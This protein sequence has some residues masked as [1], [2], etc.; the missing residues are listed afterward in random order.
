MSDGSD[1]DRH[2]D[3]K[4]ILTDDARQSQS[5]HRWGLWPA[6]REDS[7]PTWNEL[8]RYWFVRYNPLYFFSAFCVLAGVY[9]LALEIDSS[10]AVAAHGGWSLAQATL[11]S[12][13][14]LYEFL[15]IAAAGFLVHKA[16]LVRPAVILALLESVFIFDCTFRL[17]TISHLGSLGTALS[18]FWV[19][20]V[21]LKVWL[22]GKALRVELPQTFIWLVTGAAAGLAVMLQTLGMPEVDRAMVIV[23]A[24]WWGAALLAIAVI[25]RPGV[26]LSTQADVDSQIVRRRVEGSIISSGSES[27]TGRSSCP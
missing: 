26:S 21:P 5:D 20:L 17:E 15:L 12:I 13:I 24:T 22:L 1:T 27:R 6:S 11:F 18:G 14:Q 16:G 7:T 4:A 3:G 23:S 8:I 2:F 9:L 19:V 10:S 25:R